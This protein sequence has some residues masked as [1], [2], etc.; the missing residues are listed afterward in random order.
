[1]RR[2]T[3]DHASSD[4]GKILLDAVHEQAV[5]RHDGG[6]GVRLT[7]PDFDSQDPIGGKKPRCGF[8][9]FPI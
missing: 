3:R 2:G 6:N 7:G 5:I 4:T 1:M 9:D 8:G